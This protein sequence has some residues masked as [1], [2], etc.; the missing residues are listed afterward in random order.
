MKL[1][2]EKNYSLLR[3]FQSVVSDILSGAILASAFFVVDSSVESSRVTRMFD[4]AE[5]V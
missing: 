2:A 5:A 1:E 3:R 4:P